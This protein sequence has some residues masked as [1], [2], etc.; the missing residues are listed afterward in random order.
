ML[1]IVNRIEGC[2]KNKSED[3]LTTLFIKSYSIKNIPNDQLPKVS[4]EI[5]NKDL[6]KYLG[7]KNALLERN[8]EA[9]NLIK[10]NSP[11]IPNHFTRSSDIEIHQISKAYWIYQCLKFNTSKEPIEFFNER[12]IRNPYLAHFISFAALLARRFGRSEFDSARAGDARH[13]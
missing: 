7:Y 2:L 8:D 10:N 12:G 4:E 13:S 3:E 11:L 9:I 1:D 6:I 5:L